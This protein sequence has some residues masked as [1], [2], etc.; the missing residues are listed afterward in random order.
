MRQAIVAIVLMGSLPGAAQPPVPETV[1]VSASIA[2][3]NAPSGADASNVVVWLKPLQSPTPVPQPRTRPKMTQQNKRFDP[4]LLVV[5]VGTVVE[6]PNLDPFFH[7]VFSLYDGK[8]FDLGLYEAGTSRSVT[9]SKPG[10][11]FIFCNIHPEMSAT[12]VAVD[13]PYYG[14]STRS[15]E[16][17]IPGVPG[18]RYLLS[19]WPERRKLE[20]P[21]EYPKE[22][23]ISAIS[24]ASGSLGV[25]RLVE[26]E[27]VTGSHLNKYGH[28]YTPPKAGPIYK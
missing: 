6:F 2:I 14:V 9:F 27:H 19:V 3:A 13:T 20:R 1:A 22:V 17:V 12:V 4:Q 21:D 25:I 10:V 24:A 26:S 15:G 28:P 23:A 11:C 7:N 18:G 5:P 8:R 16:V